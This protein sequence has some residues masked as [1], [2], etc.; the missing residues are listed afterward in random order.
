MFVT[1]E[2]YNERLEICKECEHRVEIINI[3]ERCIICGCIIPIK[4]KIEVFKCPLNKW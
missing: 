4:A 2:K 1:T 3:T